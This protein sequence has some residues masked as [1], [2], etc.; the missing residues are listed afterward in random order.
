MNSTIEAETD[1]A[2]DLWAYPNPFTSI[3]NLEVELSQAGPVSL[4]VYDL[5]M[6]PVVRVAMEETLPEGIHPFKID[7]GNEARGI[8]FVQLISRGKTIT[9]KV[10]KQ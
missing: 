1:F 9:E 5:R 2:T 3:L 7:L 4:T 10:L 6:R 8:Y